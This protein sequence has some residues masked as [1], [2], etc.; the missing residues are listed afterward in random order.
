MATLTATPKPNELLSEE[1]IEFYRQAMNALDRGGVPFLV[2]GAYAFARYTGI[3]RH[4]KDF[5]VFVKPEDFERALDVLGREGWKTERTF[6]HWLGKAYHGDDFVDVIFSSGNG[7]ARVDDL[8]FEHAVE[9][10]VLGRPVL[11]MPAEE[12]IWSKSLIME[13]ERFDGGDVNHVIHSRVDE[14]DWDRLLRRFEPH[15]AWRVLL[16]HLTLF[17][18][19]YP[20]DAHRIP[21]RVIETLTGKLLQETAEPAD[22]DRLCRGTILSRSQ[23]LI[24]VHTW[25]YQD[26]RLEPAGNMSA[27]EIEKWTAAAEED[28]DTTQF[29]HLEGSEG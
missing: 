9:G 15:G 18:Y 28:G 3:E 5:D 16:A 6:D 7:V 27:E 14:L 24:D 26:A 11:L 25:G 20:G 22:G 17:G 21:D 23:Y 8:W 19:V 1:T 2:G 4:T 12:M 29:Q 10:E 13:R